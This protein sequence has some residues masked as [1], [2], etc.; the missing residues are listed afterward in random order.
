[1][2]I[3]LNSDFVNNYRKEDFLVFV[4]LR[5]CLF[6]KVSVDIDDEKFEI[7]VEICFVIFDFDFNK[8]VLKYMFIEDGYG[9]V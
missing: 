6:V 8:F 9:F 7:M 1:M 4:I 3:F 2:N 5:E